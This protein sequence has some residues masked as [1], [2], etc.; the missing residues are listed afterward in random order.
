MLFITVWNFMT[1]QRISH[2]ERKKGYTLDIIISNQSDKPIYEQ[3]C[4]QIKDMIIAGK[5]KEGDPLPS[6][7]FLTKELRVSV[8]TTK[9]AY[10]ELERDGFITTMTGRGSFVAGA[11][12][13]LIREENLKRIEKHMEEIARLAS[14]CGL[15]LED[16]TEMITIFYKGDQ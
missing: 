11:N 14:R 4:V 15:T 16:L 5:L 13:D 8:I 2:I 10:E 12:L 3:I 7:R 9:R 1:R 6:M